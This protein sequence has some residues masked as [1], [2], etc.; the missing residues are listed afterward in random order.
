MKAKHFNSNS[1]NNFSSQ[2][3]TI[4]NASLGVMLELL[5]DFAIAQFFAANNRK[6]RT[7]ETI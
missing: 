7:F 3:G 4:E 5:H 1:Q 6:T 2:M